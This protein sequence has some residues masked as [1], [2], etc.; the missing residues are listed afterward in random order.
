MNETN[1]KATPSEIEELKVLSDKLP[2]TYIEVQKVIKISASDY[3][4]ILQKE[5]KLTRLQKRKN[6]REYEKRSDLKHMITVNEKV[7]H[8]PH[9]IK[10]WED[11]KVEGVD[12]YYKWVDEQ[13]KYMDDKYP[14]KT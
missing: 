13:V 6:Q 2:P 5:S 3:K 8:L 7:D 12:R 14:S 9:M 10:A 11:D 1:T 4:K